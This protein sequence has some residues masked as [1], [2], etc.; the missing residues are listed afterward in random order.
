VPRP[1]RDT[2]NRLNAL[3]G[4]PAICPDSP[5]WFIQLFAARLPDDADTKALKTA[6]Y[7]DYQIEGPMI[8]WNGQ[9]F[10]RMSFQGYNTQADADAL[11]EALGNL[12]G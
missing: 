12:L 1:R 4:L 11:V 8:E 5:E 3:T 6:L 2:R 7:D 9:K 10:V